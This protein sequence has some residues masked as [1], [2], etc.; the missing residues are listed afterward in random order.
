MAKIIELAQ[1]KKK[2]R[3][4]VPECKW[5]IWQDAKHANLR[6]PNMTELKLEK[7]G[8]KTVSVSPRISDGYMTA[9][10]KPEFTNEVIAATKLSLNNLSYEQL[11][12]VVKVMLTLR[13]VPPKTFVRD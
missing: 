11:V 9:V 13:K 7:T 2:M 5:Q 10:E 3:E 4:D 1:M 6:L 8:P 12:E